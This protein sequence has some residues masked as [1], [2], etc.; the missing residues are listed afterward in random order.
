MRIKR[1]TVLQGSVGLAAVAGLEQRMTRSYFVDSVHGDDANR[2]TREDRAFATLTRAL[3]ELRNGDT[4]NL[5]RGSVFRTPLDLTGRAAGT[6]VQAYGNGPDPVVDLLATCLGAAADWT[7]TG[8]NVWSRTLPVPPGGWS[9]FLLVLDGRAGNYI[10]PA[11]AFVLAPGDYHFLPA[12][13][14]LTVYAEQN[15]AEAY[16]S[17]QYVP[18][19]L[20]ARND[21]GLLMGPP[22]DPR[23]ASAAKGCTVKNLVIQGARRNIQLRADATLVDV[24]AQFSATTN[25]QLNYEGTYRLTRVKALDAGSSLLSGEH[26]LLVAGNGST[27]VRGTVADWTDE[28]NGA[29]SRSLSGLGSPAGNH[30][31]RDWLDFPSRR[32][33]SPR[34]TLAEVTGPEHWH[35]AGDQLSVYATGNPATTY[36]VLL[37]GRFERMRVTLTDC[38]LDHAGEDAF[39]VGG[40]THPTSRID[41]VRSRISRGFENAVDLKSANVSFTDSWIWHDSPAPS[42]ALGPTI[43]IQGH[44]RDVDY[45]GCAISCALPTKGT[46]DVQEFV[47]RITSERTLWYARNQAATGVVLSHY[48]GQRHRYAFDL[49]YNDSREAQGL[50]VVAIS[51]DHDFTHCAFH[52]SSTNGTVRGLSFRGNSTL[53]AN[54]KA[55]TVDSSVVVEG[56]YV[57]TIQWDG[58]EVYLGS[59]AR[60][61]FGGL[62][63][64][65]AAFNGVWSVRDA[66]YAYNGTSGTRSF[67]TFLVPV[68]AAPP[69]SADLTGLTMRYWARLLRLRGCVIAGKTELVRIDADLGAPGAAFPIDWDEVVPAPLDANYWAQRASSTQRLVTAVRDGVQRHYSSAQ[70]VADAPVPGNLVADTAGKWGGSRNRYDATPTDSQHAFDEPE[71]TAIVVSNGTA[72]VT[73]PGHGL[74]R[75]GKVIVTGV[76]TPAKGLEGAFF[77]AGVID[78]DT[79]T[80]RAVRGTPDGPATLAGARAVTGRVKQTSAAYHSAPAYDLAPGQRD[81]Q[82]NRVPRAGRHF[83]PVTG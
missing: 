55:V 13:S 65:S 23:G 14:T 38:E 34:R 9:G 30:N 73:C 72:T 79:F 6:T 62:T 11:T 46:M 52:S 43:T 58:S 44:T 53:A 60:F 39:Q 8:T 28:G 51:G 15:P 50:P 21:I 22:D 71:I 36:T 2:G 74:R 20:G 3:A 61:L 1:R 78:A 64:E 69:A 42:S 4:L 12:T 33:V 68:S 37:G 83:G 25:I 59:G 7:A 26:C 80:Y 29:W 27:N 5:K 35:V 19:N 16:A 54:C 77:V 81:L 32:Y 17:L 10:K 49:F 67:S 56:H 66:W 48:N 41:V 57:A 70:V 31:V 75:G 82:G 76:A 63:G 24:T 18:Q 40:N 45:A 47:P